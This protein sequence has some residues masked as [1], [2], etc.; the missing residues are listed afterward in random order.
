M[1]KRIKVAQIGT[2]HDHALDA[3]RTLKFQNNLYDFVGFTDVPEDKLNPGCTYEERKENFIGVKKMTLDEILNF[4]DLDAVVIEAEDRALTKYAQTAADKGL[5]IHMDKP[6]GVNGN[7]Y[8]HLIDTVKAK[9][10]VFHTGYMYRYNLAYMRLKEDIKAGKLGDI[11]SVEAQMNCSHRKEK[12]DWLKAYPGG[13]L[14]FLG[15]HM[16]DFVYSIMGKPEEIITLSVSSGVQGTTAEDFGMA[17]FK[18]KNGVS[19]AKS[20]AVEIGGYERRQLVVCGTKGTVEI[21]PL[22][23]CV[24]DRADIYVPQTTGVRNTFDVNPDDW[25]D[26]SN[27]YFTEVRGRYDAMFRAFADYVNGKAKNPYDY[28]YE[29]ELH[30]ILL[31]ACGVK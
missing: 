8:N 6:G 5:N 11:I 7:A 25:T 24:N 13:M 20:S 2:G 14:Y 22:E 4:P 19:F 3:F 21:R 29:R 27:T 1:T 28:E 26:A 30:K 31:E 12:R 23:K 9:N 10:L 16:I 15:C 17:V 18:Y